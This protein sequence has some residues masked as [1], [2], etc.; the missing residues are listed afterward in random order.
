MS[1]LGVCMLRCKDRLL[2]RL[3]FLGL[4][5]EGHLGLGISDEDRCVKVDNS[6]R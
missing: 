4:L 6:V 5:V 2:L 3:A 1:H